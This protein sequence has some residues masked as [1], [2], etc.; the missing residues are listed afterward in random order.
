MTEKTL[1]QNL[2]IGLITFVAFIINI[3]LGIQ[4]MIKGWGVEARSYP[5]II[6]GGL[7]VAVV[8]CIMA[9]SL[10]IFSGEHKDE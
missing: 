8:T 9:I 7:F 5:W 1:Y 4:I 2:S 6:G 3:V 10:K